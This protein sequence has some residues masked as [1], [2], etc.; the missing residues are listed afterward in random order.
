MARSDGSACR[1][2]CW[3]A[4]SGS[5]SRHSTDQ[6]PESRQAET[7]IEPKRLLGVAAGVLPP[8][9]RTRL[10]PT[11]RRCR[12]PRRRAIRGRASRSPR[13]RCREPAAAR[14]RAG[15]ARSPRR[16]SARRRRAGIPLAGRHDHAEKAACEVALRGAP[17]QD[18]RE[19][20]GDCGEPDRDSRAIARRLP[21]RLLGPVAVPV[22]H[23]GGL[24]RQAREAVRAAGAALERAR[25]VDR[26]ELPRE[27][28]LAHAPSPRRFA[29]RSPRA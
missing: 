26:R 25:G 19:P 7:R 16:P 6:R 3:R 22:Q 13:A 29:G 18:A 24:Q 2:S 4:G 15:R 14:R 27:V 8:S 20:A 23:H 28:A 12:A 5:P 17:R 11:A 10:R 21:R 1:S 9:R